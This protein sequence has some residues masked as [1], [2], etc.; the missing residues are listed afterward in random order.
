MRSDDASS[1]DGQGPETE[2]TVLQDVADV[3]VSL[4]TIRVL[5]LF[6]YS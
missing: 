4:R 3:Y 2:G 1:C 6:A 5:E